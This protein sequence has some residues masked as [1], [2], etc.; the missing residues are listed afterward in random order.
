M[1][2]HKPPWS[3]VNPHHNSVIRF[4]IP[5][6][7]LQYAAGRSSIGYQELDEKTKDI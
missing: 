7:P 1:K 3:P 5:R 4:R 6:L 2:S